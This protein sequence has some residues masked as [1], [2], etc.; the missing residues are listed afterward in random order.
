M[1]E[2]GTPIPTPTDDGFKSKV[3]VF[4]GGGYVSKGVYRPMFNCRMKSNQAT[5]FCPVCIKAIESA[6]KYYTE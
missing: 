4:E 1:I 6:I 5:G 3:G 2:S